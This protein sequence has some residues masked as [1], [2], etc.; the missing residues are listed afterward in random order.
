[1]VYA[2]DSCNTIVEV[3]VVEAIARVCVCASVFASQWKYSKI[4]RNRRWFAPSAHVHRAGKRTMKNASILASLIANMYVCGFLQLMELQWQRRQRVSFAFVCSIESRMRYMHP[5]LFLFLLSVQ[6][7]AA[8]VCYSIE[9]CLSI[10]SDWNSPYSLAMSKRISN[11][12]RWTR[13]HCCCC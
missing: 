7:R 8:C 5:L 1:M 12:F 2:R 11:A 6:A 10:P 4:L 3:V 9:N 13:C